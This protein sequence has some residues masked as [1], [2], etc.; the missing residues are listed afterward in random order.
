MTQEAI[1]IT[2]EKIHPDAVALLKDYCLCYTGARFTQ[3]ELVAR[4]EREQPVAILSR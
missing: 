3:D 2:E 1:V 4:V